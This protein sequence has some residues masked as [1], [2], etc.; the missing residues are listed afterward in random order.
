MEWWTATLAGLPVACT[1]EE[2]PSLSTQRLQQRV[3]LAF[4]NQGF[5]E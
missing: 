3:V 2:L 1:N 5:L 4:E